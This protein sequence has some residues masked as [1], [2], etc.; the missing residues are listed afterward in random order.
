[1]KQLRPVDAVIVGGGWTGL[2]MAK[3]IG[4]RTGLSI[5]VLE[6][7]PSRGMAECQQ[8]MDELDTQIRP[9]LLQNPAT[10]TVT[11]RH[12]SADRAVPIRTVGSFGPGSGIGGSGE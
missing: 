7:G 3:E 1:M 11:M 8:G 6:R 9:R 10:E 4:S 12:S 2:L 5:L